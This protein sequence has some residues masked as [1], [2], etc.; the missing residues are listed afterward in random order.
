MVSKC[1]HCKT[2]ERVTSV[3]QRQ[4]TIRCNDCGVQQTILLA[5]RDYFKPPRADHH[6]THPHHYIAVMLGF[7][8]VLALVLLVNVVHAL[9]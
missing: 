4:T 7:C 8:C 9:P 2:S 6:R 1:P 5:P 3:G